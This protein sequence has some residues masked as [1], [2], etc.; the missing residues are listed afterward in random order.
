MLSLTLK[1]IKAKKLRF[2]LTSVAVI[3]GVAFMAG[4]L[5]LTDTIKQNYNDVATNVYKNTD[6]V[7]RSSQSVEGENGQTVRGDVN[8]SL[9][10][11]VRTVKGVAA[12]EAQ[13]VGVAV[14]VGHDG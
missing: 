10:E 13:Q 8:A 11:K 3:L 2:V 9:V 6:A 1:S 7:V 12:A 4:T 5:V 14:V